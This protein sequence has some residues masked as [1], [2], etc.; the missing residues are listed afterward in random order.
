MR[1]LIKTVH[2]CAIAFGSGLLVSAPAYAA[3][4]RTLAAGLSNSLEIGGRQSMYDFL[5]P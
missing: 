4:F 2:Y 1:S 3:T 5:L